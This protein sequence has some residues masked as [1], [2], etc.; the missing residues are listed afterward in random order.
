VHRQRIAGAIALAPLALLT[1]AHLMVVPGQLADANDFNSA[2]T[3]QDGPAHPEVVVMIDA[4]GRL[5]PTDSIV[6]Y[7]RARTMTLLTDRR[8]FQTTD[9]ERIR[10]NADYWVQRTDWSFWQPG[11]DADTVVELGF[12]EVWSSERFV[13]WSTGR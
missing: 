8:S 6:A 4:V 1:I 12:T 9:F 3:V 10:T 2:G 13:L 11:L 5:T 7:Y